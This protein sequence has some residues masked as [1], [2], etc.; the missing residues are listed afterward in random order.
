MA[1]F[2][3]LAELVEMLEPHLGSRL[4]KPVATIL[5]GLATLAFIAG[6]LGVIGGV[7][8]EA[9]IHLS[10]PRSISIAPVTTALPSVVA[11]APTTSPAPAP[12]AELKA[13]PAKLTHTAH[14]P[15][16]V[17]VAKSEA[18]NR[19]GCGSAPAGIE[20]E[21]GATVT[22]HNVPVIG[23]PTSLRACGH[24][25]INAEGGGLRRDVPET[26]TP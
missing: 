19:T 25:Q 17:P 9:Y 13:A 20:T 22:L 16:S 3:K 7:G 10:Q 14:K 18:P 11:V 26:P 4:A 12:L 24:S 6:C 15:R 8:Y 2:T 23:F 5:V 21:D 1:E